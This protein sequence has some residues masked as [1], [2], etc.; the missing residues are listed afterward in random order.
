MI[1]LTR[2]PRVL[3]LLP[4]L[5]SSLMAA[6][7]WDQWRGPNRDDR[8]EETGLKKDFKAA[9]ENY[10]KVYI[11]YKYPEWQAAALFQT[12]LCDEQLGEWS[13][14]VSDYESLLSEFPKSEFVEKAKPRLE[15][16]RQ[17]AK[18]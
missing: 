13:K 3:L 15:V 6:E 9:L 5:C 10:L 1:S 17:N 12:G 4:M 14:V 7:S 16:A 2:L 11:L 18:K 8:S